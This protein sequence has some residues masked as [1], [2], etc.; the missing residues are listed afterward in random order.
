M[1][2]LPQEA[3]PVTCAILSQSPF[4]GYTVIMALWADVSG[5]VMFPTVS[6]NSTLRRLQSDDLAGIRDLYPTFPG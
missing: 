4:C 5:S 2:W 3:S 1:F 6:A